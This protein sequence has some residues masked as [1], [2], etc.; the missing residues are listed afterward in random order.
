MTVPARS[1]R[2]FEAKKTK[3]RRYKMSGEE[4]L[5]EKHWRRVFRIAPAVARFCY[6]FTTAV[7]TCKLPFAIACEFIPTKLGSLRVHK[8]SISIN[9][10]CL[11]VGSRKF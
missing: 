9:G 4:R 3:K 8:S 11:Y 7:I 2:E 10:P 6:S 1:A 5:P